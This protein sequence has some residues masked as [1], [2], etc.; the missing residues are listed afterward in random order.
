MSSLNKVMLIGRVG[1][2]PEIRATQAG[3]KLA[4]FSIATSEYWKDKQGEKQE[5]TEWHNIVVFN[6]N[7]AKIVES[8]VKKGGQVYIEGHLQTR[9]WTDKDNNDR[10]TTEVVLHG[11]NAKLVLLGGKSDAKNDSVYNQDNFQHPINNDL[12][13]EIPF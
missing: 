12:D 8:Y 1:K 9:K 3:K 10:Y 7:I 2:D 6:E 5:K 13:D 11:F 4:S